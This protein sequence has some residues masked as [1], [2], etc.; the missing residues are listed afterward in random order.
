[1]SSITGMEA[2]ALKSKQD[3][4]STSKKNGIQNNTIGDVKLSE[5]ASSYYEELKAKYGDAEFI[6]VA[7]DKIATAKEQTAN[8]NS[9]KSMIVLISASEVEEMASNEETRNKNEKFIEDSM[10]QMP[11]LLKQLKESGTT[12]K[13]FGIEINKDG[14]SSFFAVLDKAQVAQK[15]RIEKNL[16]EKREAAKEEKKSGVY[17]KDDLLHKKTQKEDLTTVSASSMEELLQK[18]QDTLYA[19]KSDML[20]TEQEKM[21]GQNFDLRF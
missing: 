16:A 7:D 12:I 21:V 8:Y 6:L 20:I 13:T 14:T 5:K 11:D 18:I 2:F 17:G 1:M 15:E 10:A 4:Y 3:I 9:D 19:A